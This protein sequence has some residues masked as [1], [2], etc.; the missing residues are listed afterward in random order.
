MYLSID[1]G[2]TNCGIVIF[3]KESTMLL[4]NDEFVEENSMAY[5]VLYSATLNLRQLSH[6]ASIFDMTNYL[7]SHLKDLK[8]QFWFNKLFIERQMKA[9]AHQMYNSSLHNCCVETAVTSFAISIDIPYN[10]VQ[11]VGWNQYHELT[12]LH[13]SVRLYQRMQLLQNIS[14]REK[15]KKVHEW[16]CCLIALYGTISSS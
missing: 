9:A 1:P 3:Q 8:T 10:V 5:K 16:D 7:I 11:A 13:K 14:N 6:S 4:I 15:L 12:G 2:T